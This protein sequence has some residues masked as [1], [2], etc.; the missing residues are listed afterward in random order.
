MEA[1]D[2]LERITRL[3]NRWAF[4]YGAWYERI[5]KLQNRWVVNYN[6]WHDE[7]GRF[8]FAGHG[9]AVWPKNLISVDFSDNFKTYSHGK[10]DLRMDYAKLPP[11]RPDQAAVSVSNAYQAGLSKAINQGLREMRQAQSRQELFNALNCLV[12]SPH[13]LARVP[14]ET[15]NNYYTSTLVR[16]MSRTTA[17]KNKD[18][19]TLYQGVSGDKYNKRATK[20][21]VLQLN[22][23]ASTSTSAT[24]A[25]SYAARRGGQDGTAVQ[26]VYSIKCPPGTAMAIP[27]KTKISGGLGKNTGM[28]D[29]SEVVLPPS[30]TL[31]INKVGNIKTVTDGGKNYKVREI[32][33]EVVPYSRAADELAQGDYSR[34][35]DKD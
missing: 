30:T 12:K 19:I 33:L 18:E 8:T 27:T 31:R 5:Q 20:G 4:N 1:Q 7:L 25:T 21:S 17:F 14:G 9:R 35:E 10:K 15:G 3:K 24:V 22:N 26:T 11:Y 23:F 6:P 28:S 34:Y 32:Q 29:E 13:G 16:N 2:Q